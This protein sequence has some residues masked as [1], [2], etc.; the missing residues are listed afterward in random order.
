[1]V[2]ERNE[3]ICF[4]C[5][6]NDL[7]QIFQIQFMED[8]GQEINILFPLK[9]TILFNIEQRRVFLEVENGC[10]ELLAREEITNRIDLWTGRATYDFIMNHQYMVQSIAEKFRGQWPEEELPFG[11]EE[12]VA[13]PERF[14]LMTKYVGFPE[15][16]YLSLPMRNQ[17]V[18]ESFLQ[19][20]EKLR[21]T[22]DVYTMLVESDIPS[23]KALNRILYTN[24]GLCYYID[25]LNTFWKL[26][27]NVDLYAR[28][29]QSKQVFEVLSFLHDYPHTMTFFE[30]YIRIKSVASLIRR[31]NDEWK[32]LRFY[33][34][35]YSSM[36]EIRRWQEHKKWGKKPLFCHLDAN[37]SR[38]IQSVETEI[39]DDIIDDYAIVRL[40]TSDD[41][42]KT[43]CEL[44]NCL[45]NW[46]DYLDSVVFAIK[47]GDAY[48][49]AIQVREGKVITVLGYDNRTLK[50]DEEI[51]GIYEKWVEKW[52]LIETEFLR[53][54]QDEDDLPFD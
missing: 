4:S 21:S 18:D 39:K 13:N 29:L 28:L 46:E 48:G 37:Y 30:D 17:C 14:I 32:D 44:Q 2:T 54:P 8:E 5:E 52:G 50:N 9:E 10:G 42:I 38:P 11:V 22:D 12:L 31:I 7:A 33:A 35:S 3:N 24:P 25:E 34:V 47:K 15:K 27:N 51:Y 16:F 49:A 41:F 20:D 45:W 43:S 53:E 26:I 1:M 40:Y 36:S 6:I 23:V 19:I